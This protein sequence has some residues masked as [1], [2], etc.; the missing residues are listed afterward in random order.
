VKVHARI[1]RLAVAVGRAILEGI[2]RSN[3]E[4]GIDVPEL[5]TLLKVQAAPIPSGTDSE[6]VAVPAR[7]GGPGVLPGETVVVLLRGRFNN[8]AI[9]LLDGL[10]KLKSL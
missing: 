3:G 2:D 4:V 6:L 8:D 1:H 5:G 7:Q 9:A 10:R